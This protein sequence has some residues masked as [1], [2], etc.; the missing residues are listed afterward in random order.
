MSQALPGLMSHHAG[1]G[2]DPGRDPTRER[3]APLLSEARASTPRRRRLAL[4][5]PAA[6]ARTRPSGRVVVMPTHMG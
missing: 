5:V 4:R 2:T 3:L 1:L 6:A